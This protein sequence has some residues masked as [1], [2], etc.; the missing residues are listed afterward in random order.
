M[1]TYTLLATF[2]VRENYA[3][4]DGFDG[5]FAW[6]NKGGKEVVVQ[7]NI[8]IT[9]YLGTK[10][11][12][13]DALVNVAAPESDDYYAYDLVDQQMIELS[14]A[15]IERVRKHLDKC[16]GEEFG[17]VRYQYGTEYTF[18]WAVKQLQERGELIVKGDQMYSSYKLKIGA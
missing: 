3:A 17:F 11:A 7:D 15:T 9:E 1:I 13:W 5:T 8:S 6:K 2:Q 18:D 10:M 4:H 12:T 16:A 14:E